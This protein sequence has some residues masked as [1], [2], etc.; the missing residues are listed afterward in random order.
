MWGAAGLDEA[1]PLLWALLDEA[2]SHGT[3][4]LFMRMAE[5]INAH[6]HQAEGRSMTHDVLHDVRAG[7]FLMVGLAM[8]A[9]MCAVA[10]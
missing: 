1:L 3:V 10:A 7:F 4:G 8:L 9:F 5:W 6:R 2:R